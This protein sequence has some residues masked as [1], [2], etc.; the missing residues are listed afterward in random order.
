[1]NLKILWN[2]NRYKLKRLSEIN[3][4]YKNTFLTND[5]NN[6]NERKNSID[7]VYKS[8][9]T[10]SPIFKTKRNQYLDNK[11]NL[12]YSENKEQFKI[13][14]EK[15][16]K[17][18][19]DKIVNS[20]TGEDSEKIIKQVKDMK[21]KI[22]FMKCVMDYSLPSLILTKVRNIEK[23]LYFNNNVKYQLTPIET[24]KNEIRQLNDLRTSYFNNCINITPM[25]K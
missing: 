1:M 15:R 2:R 23:N 6:I 25:K 16:N 9:F 18:E 21:G 19:K 12:V 5:N 4:N 14:M 8:I 10:S 20:N 22:H 17:L 3:N 13:I 24:R 11:L 7:Y